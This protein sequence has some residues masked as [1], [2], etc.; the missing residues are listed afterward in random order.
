MKGILGI[1]HAVVDIYDAYSSAYPGGNALNVAA[2]SRLFFGSDACFIGVLGT[3][4]F[5]DHVL[6]VL[7]DLCV[8]T[9]RVRCAVGETGRTLVDVAADGDRVFL[10]TNKGGVQA[11]LSLNL[12]ER[13]LDIAGR[14]GLVHASVYSGINSS[15]PKLSERARI[16]Y[17]FSEAQDDRVDLSVLKY[18][19]CAFFSA[20]RFTEVER[21]NFVEECFS[22]GATVVVLTAGESGAYGYT[23]TSSA[24]CPSEHVSVVDALGAGDGFIA[25]FLHEWQNS[26]DLT[27]ALAAGARCGARACTY[28]GAFGS[29]TEATRAQMDALER[30]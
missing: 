19:E 12:G 3:D 13:D 27:R 15:L 21:V 22:R 11:D 14:Y 7:R 24:F 16:S 8:D 4:E 1:G 9:S 18:V 26:S 2:Y 29:P 23:R 10:A 20:S 30:R 5:G 6:S 17:D 25:G 28:R